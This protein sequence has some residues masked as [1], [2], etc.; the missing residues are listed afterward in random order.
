MNFGGI[1]SHSGFAGPTKHGIV[2][3][4]CPLPG[5]LASFACI[6][7]ERYFRSRYYPGAQCRCPDCGQD[8]ELPPPSG[9]SSAA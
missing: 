3:R 6:A 8:L 9:R 5:E 2:V 7:C 1:S 4:C